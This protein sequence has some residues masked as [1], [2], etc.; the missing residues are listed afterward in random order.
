MLEDPEGTIWLDSA[1][2]LLRQH[3]GRWQTVIPG[4]PAFVGNKL[5]VD[6]PG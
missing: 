3:H 1:Q 5:A 2:G 6:P 4:S